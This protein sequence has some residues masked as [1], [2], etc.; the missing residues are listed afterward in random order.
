MS[1][2]KSVVTPSY[3]RGPSPRYIL[4]SYIGQAHSI[5]GNQCLWPSIINCFPSS[6]P[7]RSDI[8]CDGDH[9]IFIFTR[10]GHDQPMIV[11]T[12]LL[13]ICCWQLERWPWPYTA[14]LPASNIVLIHPAA[15]SRPSGH[16][17]DS[18]RFTV[19]AYAGHFQRM[20]SHTRVH[21]L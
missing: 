3:S 1:S 15:K 19:G 12:I 10:S 20:M 5:S 6:V 18:R 21:H 7:Y 16:S 2:E 17:S 11:G 4:T 14:A 13:S 8:L 9:C